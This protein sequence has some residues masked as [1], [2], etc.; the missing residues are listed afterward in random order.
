LPL[1]VVFTFSDGSMQK[2][3]YPAEVWSTNTSFYD[4][5]YQFP[6]KKVAKVEID[7]EKRTVDIDKD[8]NVWPRQAPAAV[9]P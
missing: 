5:I 3:D 6:G 7:P 9:K 4:R 1:H 2:Y 8:N